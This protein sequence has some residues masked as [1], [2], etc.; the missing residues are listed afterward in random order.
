V[1]YKA[2]DDVYILLADSYED[3]CAKIREIRDLG[4]GRKI[5]SMLWYFTIKEAKALRLHNFEDVAKG[6]VAHAGKYAAGPH[7]GHH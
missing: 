1:T 7:V 2:G 6:E 3:F 5:I 4:D